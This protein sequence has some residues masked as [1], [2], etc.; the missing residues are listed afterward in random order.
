MRIH[1]FGINYFK[2]I[3]PEQWRSS[4]KAYNIPQLTN[5]GWKGL[6]I[7]YQGIIYKCVNSSRKY[8]TLLINNEEVKLSYKPDTF[9]LYSIGFKQKT[10]SEIKKELLDLFPS[11][12]LIIGKGCQL[13]G[14]V[15]ATLTKSNGEVITIAWNY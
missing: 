12:T 2:E 3:Y 1:D 5:N 15:D 4:N 14:D 11:S 8:V 9:Y 13:H 6:D 10:D 7:K